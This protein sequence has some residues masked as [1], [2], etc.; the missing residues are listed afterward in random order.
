MPLS[1]FFP[2]P[3]AFF[4]PFSCS[5]QARI[6]SSYRL[7]SVPVCFRP[8]MKIVCQ[9]SDIFL[10]RCFVVIVPCVSSLSCRRLTPDWVWIYST[11]C[12]PTT[13]RPRSA[14]GCPVGYSCLECVISRARQSNNEAGFWRV[15]GGQAQRKRFLN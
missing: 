7:L 9:R 3:V 12:L 5:R 4:V 1:G 2:L 11:C 6:L 13:H 10:L 14:A 8:M 15:T